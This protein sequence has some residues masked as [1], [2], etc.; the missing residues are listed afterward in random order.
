ML[1]ALGLEIRGGL[2]ANIFYVALV[3]APRA[4]VL[5][6]VARPLAFGDGFLDIWRRQRTRG[7]PLSILHLSLSGYLFVFFRMLSFSALSEVIA[8]TTPLLQVALCVPQ[9]VDPHQVSHF[10]T[11]L[12]TRPNANTRPRGCSLCLG[13]ATPAKNKRARTLLTRQRQWSIVGQHFD[14]LAL[15]WRFRVSVEPGG[16][17][18]HRA[19]QLPAA[20]LRD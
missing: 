17:A 3:P 16:A 5:V 14:Q 13:S 15:P 6:D 1:P 7:V 11:M 4:G 2:L 9:H 20:Q 19:A 10:S 12:A 8:G 18:T